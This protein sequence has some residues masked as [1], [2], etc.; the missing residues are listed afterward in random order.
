MLTLNEQYLVDAE[1]NRT[2]VVLDLAEYERLLVALEELDDLRAYA[3]AK[4]F[5]EV[6]MPLEQV[7]AEIGRGRG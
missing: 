7:I 4:A 5:G 6:A 2:K 1:G 3:E